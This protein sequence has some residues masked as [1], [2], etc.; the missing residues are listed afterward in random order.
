V[1]ARKFFG[2]RG[3]C[4]TINLP[5]WSGSKPWASFEGYRSLKHIQAAPG[6]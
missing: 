2:K 1:F 3:M 6:Y 4:L 5:S